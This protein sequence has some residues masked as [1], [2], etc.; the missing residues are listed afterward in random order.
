MKKYYALLLFAMLGILANAQASWDGTAATWT[1]GNGTNANPYLIE[2]GQHL[3]YLSEQV[4]NGETYKNRFFK[5]A[6]NLDMGANADHKFTPIGFYDRYMNTEVQGGIIDNSKYFLGQF[7][8]NNKKIDNIHIYYIDENPENSVGGTGLFAC[9]SENSVIKNL[10]IGENSIVEGKDA[11]GAIVGA[12]EGGTV[13]NCYNEAV[14]QVEDGGWSSGGI[15]GSGN[16]GKISGCYNTGIIKGY[17]NVGG[18]VGF[19]DSKITISNC[20]NTAMVTL[21]GFY[22]GGL[23]GFVS[24]ATISNCYTTGSV[25]N[26]I[27]A[28]A[29][30]GTTE[31]TSVIDNCYYCK[32]RSGITDATTGVTEKNEAEMKDP[33]FTALLNGNQSPVAWANDTRNINEG[34]PILTWQNNSGS[35]IQNPIK[36]LDCNIYAEGYS[37]VVE[38]ATAKHCQMIVTDLTGITIANPAFTGKYSLDITNSGIYVV[39]VKADSQQYTTKVVIK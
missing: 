11:T 10:G 5:L 22:A 12:V 2:N 33:S 34:F 39:T 31:K 6:D 14:L 26:D 24:E 23:V 18:I 15:A 7:D 13:E 9:I 17:N 19:A 38:C 8:G 28:C 32:E 4:R 36:A 21:G 1:K 29:A 35:G 37:V 3:A 25:A 30:I 20:Y 27:S 16:S